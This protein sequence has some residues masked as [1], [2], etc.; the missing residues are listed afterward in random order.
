MKKASSP[1]SLRGCGSADAPEFSIN[2]LGSELSERRNM[3]V[4]LDPERVRP[5]G[6]RCK[7]S[8]TAIGFSGIMYWEAVVV[9][10]V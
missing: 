6:I 7:S 5:Q 10:S 9:L 4:T 8:L 2:E 1:R 3:D